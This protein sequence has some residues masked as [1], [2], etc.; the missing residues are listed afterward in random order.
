MSFQDPATHARA[1]QQAGF[2]YEA[3]RRQLAE[4]LHERGDWQSQGRARGRASA[5]LTREAAARRTVVTEAIPLY[6][7]LARYV[8][9]GLDDAVDRGAAGPF[10]VAEEDVVEA[11]YLAALEAVQSSAPPSAVYPWLR[12]IAREQLRQAVALQTEQEALES[13][14]ES[15]VAVPDEE[16]GWPEELLRV[17]DVLAAP[18]TMVPEEA[19]ENEETRRTLDRLLTR[20]PERWR[21][22]FLLSAVDG[23]PDVE[24]ARVEGLALGDVRPIVDASRAFVR[25]WLLSATE[26][27]AV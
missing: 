26:A 25:E 15:V 12:R 22:V 5:E 24:I 19:F 8:R 27:E 1:R 13:S 9:R 6:D 10:S 11:T 18:D 17:I 14:I 7:S 4:T 20:L 23:W 16:D 2:R 21:E 3:A